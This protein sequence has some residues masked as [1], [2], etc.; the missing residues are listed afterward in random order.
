MILA[1]KV[2]DERILDAGLK[3][4]ITQEIWIIKKKKFIVLST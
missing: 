1:D 2:R 4:M 3:Q